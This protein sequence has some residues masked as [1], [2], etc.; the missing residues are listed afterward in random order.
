MLTISSEDKKILIFSLV[1][2]ISANAG[3][4][5]FTLEEVTFSIFPIV[6]CI[7]A[8][9]CM[10]QQYQ[11]REIGGDIPVL[12]AASF[13]LGALGYAASIRVAMPELG[14]NFLPVML[15][16]GLIFWMLK[17]VGMFKA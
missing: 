11:T 4:T 6:S 14:S 1:A 8:F 5:G 12:T 2:G 10:L 16:M 15:C 3:L 7:L 9:Y 13:I 17:K